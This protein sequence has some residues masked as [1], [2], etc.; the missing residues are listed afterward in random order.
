M[1][2]GTLALINGAVQRRKFGGNEERWSKS[3]YA[4]SEMEDSKGPPAWMVEQR[5]WLRFGELS[6][7]LGPVLGAAGLVLMVLGA[8]I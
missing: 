3:A 4:R 6:L 2:L 7:K 5:I 1:V 8:L